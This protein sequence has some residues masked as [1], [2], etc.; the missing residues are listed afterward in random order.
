MRDRDRETQQFIVH[1]SWLDYRDIVQM[2][3]ALVG[4]VAHVDVSG[5]N[6]TGVLAS[7]YIDMQSERAREDS[8]AVGLSDELSLRIAE[9]AGKIQHLVNDRAHRRTREHDTHLVRQREELAAD[10]LE[11]NRIYGPLPKTVLRRSFRR[12]FDHR[13]RILHSHHSAPWLVRRYFFRWSLRSLYIMQR[14]AAEKMFQVAPVLLRF[15]DL[16]D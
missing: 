1:E 5:A 2:G 11:R 3:P 8:Y 13:G 7:H 12:G 15:R 16:F 9:A 6:L 4:V 14:M 10:Y